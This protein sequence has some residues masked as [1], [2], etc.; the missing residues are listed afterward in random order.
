MTIPHR[1]NTALN[2]A[3]ISTKPYPLA[4][5]KIQKKLAGAIKERTPRLQAVSV[6][7][8]SYFEVEINSRFQ[9]EERKSLGNRLRKK[10]RIRYA[11]AR[12]T[13][14]VR[15]VPEFMGALQWFS[16]QLV[17]GLG[18][19]GMTL[20]M[21]VTLSDNYFSPLEYSFFFLSTFDSYWYMSRWKIVRPALDLNVKTR[22]KAYSRPTAAVR[23]ISIYI[24]EIWST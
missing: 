17:S 23:Y 2:Q 12:I 19:G 5:D 1:I 9:N 21:A 11:R 16:F 15:L 6:Q 7:G 20:G 10:K 14:G 13:S 8:K 3:K 22:F 24:R 18:Q 4:K